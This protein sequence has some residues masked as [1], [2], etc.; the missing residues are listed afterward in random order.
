MTRPRSS[1]GGKL[2]AERGEGHVDEGHAGHRQA[3]GEDRGDGGPHRGQRLESRGGER[4]GQ[5]AAPHGRQAAHEGPA[6]GRAR[7][8]MAGRRSTPRAPIRA[9]PPKNQPIRARPLMPRRS[10]QKMTRRASMGTKARLP[11]VPARVAARRGREPPETGEPA[12]ERRQPGGALRLGP[13][14]DLGQHEQGQAEMTKEA[15]RGRRPPG[16]HHRV[17]RQEAG[18]GRAERPGQ[19]AHE[20]E[21][22]VRPRPGPGRWPGRAATPGSRSRR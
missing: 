5:E 21:A 9:W 1:G 2:L 12:A 16:S 6:R 17:R 18:Q 7:R 8:A 10:R 11:R 19:G 20:L 13:G 22:G 3:G 14:P 15:R 4:Q